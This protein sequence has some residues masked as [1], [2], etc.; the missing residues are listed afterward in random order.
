MKNREKMES[1]LSGD[2]KANNYES[3]E[4]R[5]ERSN[6]EGLLDADPIGKWNFHSAF[7]K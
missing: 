3:A 6:G 4:R 1:S 7:N 2:Y 5:M